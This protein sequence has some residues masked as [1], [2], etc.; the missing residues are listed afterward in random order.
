MK[1]FWYYICF[2]HQSHTNTVV[3]RISFWNVRKEEQRYIIYREEGAHTPSLYFMTQNMKK[4][5]TFTFTFPLHYLYWLKLQCI[6]NAH[7]T[8]IFPLISC[9]S[10]IMDRQGGQA[11]F[12]NRLKSSC[13]SQFLC[14]ISQIWKGSQQTNI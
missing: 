5:L 10:Y 14:F 2:Y 6:A 3:G 4:Q 11:C 13:I 1:A 9:K 8:M 12:C 7:G